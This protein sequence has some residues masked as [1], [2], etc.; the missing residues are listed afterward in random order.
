MRNIKLTGPR[1]RCYAPRWLFRTEMD[2]EKKTFE[3]R[4]DE[5]IRTYAKSIGT[6]EGGDGTPMEASSQ[7]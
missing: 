7:A 1:R 4:F 3:K 5:F 6:I 2:V